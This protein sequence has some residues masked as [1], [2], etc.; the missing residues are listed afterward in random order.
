MIVSSN[1]IC[2]LHIYHP[3]S[4]MTDSVNIKS[5]ISVPDE[6]NADNPMYLV[7]LLHSLSKAWGTST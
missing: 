1:A 2:Y 6:T 3:L 7:N 5:P 4:L